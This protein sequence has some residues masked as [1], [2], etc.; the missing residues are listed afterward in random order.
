MMRPLHEVDMEAD[1]LTTCKRS[2]NDVVAHLSHQERGCRSVRFVQYE[3]GSPEVD[4]STPK[5]GRHSAVSTAAAAC[6]SCICRTLRSSGRP[7]CRV[8][9]V[10]YD[11]FRL[12]QQWHQTLPL[13]LATGPGRETCDIRIKHVPF[14][15]KRGA[16]VFA[17]A[18]IRIARRTVTRTVIMMEENRQ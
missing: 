2:A 5:P 6:L 11:A 15:D 7:G 13:A 9:A 1:H 12:R 16:A 17:E 8:I 18:L 14:C 3:A 4:R 10:V